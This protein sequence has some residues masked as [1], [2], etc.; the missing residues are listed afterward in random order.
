MVKLFTKKNEV[1][2]KEMTKPGHLV[3]EDGTIFSGVSFG[4]QSSAYGEVV[5][6]TSMTGYQ[7][8]L[9]DP[10]FAGQIVVLTYP[11]V[12]NYG[13]NTKDNE[14]GNIQVSGLVVRQHET[15]PSHW[16]MSTS[17]NQFLVSENIA[18]LSEVDTR[19]LTKHLRSKGVMMGA[20]SIGVSPAVALKKL[21]TTPR[22]G[23]SSLVELV[24]TKKISTWT[25]SSPKSAA[26]VII[27]DYGAKYNILRL[28]SQ[29]GL[30]VISV[31]HNTTLEEILDLRPDGIVLSPGPGDPLTLTSTPNLLNKLVTTLPVLGICLGHQLIAQ[32]FGAKTYKLP[33]GHRGANHPVKNEESGLI[34]ITSQNHGYAVDKNTLPKELLVTHTNLNDSTVEGIRH[35]SLPILGIQ[36]HS[37][38]APGPLDTINLFEDFSKLVRSKKQQ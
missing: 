13:I 16:S 32:T 33:F 22:Y 28:L 11:M 36:Y 7:E 4:K 27:I 2:C 15:N 8:M 25:S 21:T 34:S 10:S 20:I 38:A 35:T 19:A 18:G 31:P 9:T 26:R 3:L 5:F 30:E 14:S 23:T 6:T 29:S 37:E 12:G 24:S 17:L 1:C